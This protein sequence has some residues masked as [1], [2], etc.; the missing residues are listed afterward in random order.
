MFKDQQGKLG[1]HSRGQDQGRRSLQKLGPHK[2]PLCLRLIW[3]Q[4]VLSRETTGQVKLSPSET[5]VK[6]I[7]GSLVAR[8]GHSSCS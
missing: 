5:R 8:C 6:G 1:C 7:S 3:L 2:G 4:E